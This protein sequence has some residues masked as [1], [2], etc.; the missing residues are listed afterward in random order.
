MR[1]PL[2]ALS[3]LFSFS[4]SLLPGSLACLVARLPAHLWWFFGRR[5][6]RG[7]T[8][9]PCVCP[10]AAARTTR[11]PTRAHTHPPIHPPT[12]A[13]QEGGAAPRPVCRLP[14][15]LG[16][17][18]RGHLPRHLP[19]V[20]HPEVSASLFRAFFESPSVFAAPRHLPPL[21]PPRGA[22]GL[23]ALF[24]PTCLPSH[25][26]PAPC[27]PPPSNPQGDGDGSAAGRGAHRP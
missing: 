13:T 16:P 19:P 21:L 3:S 8:L 9:S 24:V 11:A 20:L 17:A 12:H 14:G 18:A 1:E 27:L 7:R 2:R 15:C 5:A 10:P 4:L 23:P 25:S 22:R 26:P 6:R